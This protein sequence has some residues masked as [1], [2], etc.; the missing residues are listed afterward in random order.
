MSET[1]N[2]NTT[3]SILHGCDGKC[4]R[5]AVASLPQ[6]LST[7]PSHVSRIHDIEAQLPR[8]MQPYIAVKAH[9]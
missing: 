3:L 6:F 4:P 7:H 8:V 5:Q 1:N 9:G 2:A